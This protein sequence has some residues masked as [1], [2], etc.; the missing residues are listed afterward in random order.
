MLG[1]VQG[2]MDTITGINIQKLQQQKG[3]VKKLIDH[4][5]TFK[6]VEERDQLDIRAQKMRKKY[7]EHEGEYDFMINNDK[8][9][10]RKGKEEYLLESQAPKQSG[11][12][13]YIPGLSGKFL[14]SMSALCLHVNF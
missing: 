7:E 1:I 2:I 8:N 10:G 11:Y 12:R 13:N 4:I 6:T 14:Q 5:S 9:R 3:P